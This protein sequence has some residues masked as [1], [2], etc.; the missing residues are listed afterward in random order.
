LACA[1]DGE[2]FVN[3]SVEGRVA[4]E[5]FGES[6]G[7]KS[8]QYAFKCHRTKAEE[9]SA[10]EAP[11]PFAVN[12]VAFHP[13]TGAFATGGGDGFVCVWDG[14]KKKR[15][16]QSARFPREC[17]VSGVQRGRETN[18]RRGEPRAAKR[19]GGHVSAD[20]FSDAVFVR[21]V[22]DAEVTPKRK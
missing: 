7:D 14:L 11:K 3:A 22:E 1:P 13:V 2:S 17:R 6:E 16:W 19:N 15:L 18:R 10:E 12:A 9:A 5:R 4:W 21:R 8:S 20:A